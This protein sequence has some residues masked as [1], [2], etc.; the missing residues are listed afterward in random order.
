MAVKQPYLL[1]PFLINRLVASE[2]SL[3]NEKAL[4]AISF[5]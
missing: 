5:R 4:G 2:N 1:I 3:R